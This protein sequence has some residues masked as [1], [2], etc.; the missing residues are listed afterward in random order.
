MKKKL[1]TTLLSLSAVFCLLGL[2]ACGNDTPTSSSSPEEEHLAYK[3]ADDGSSYTVM[4]MGT[5]TGTDVII[6]ATYQD[7]PVTAIHEYAF[8]NGKCTSITFDENSQ[9]TSIPDMAFHESEKLT[10]IAFPASLSSIGSSVFSGCV[11]LASITVDENNEYFQSIDDNLYSKD[12]KTLIQYAIGKTETE[13]TVPDSV[14]TINGIAFMDC[15]SL[16]SVT[17]GSEVTTVGNSAFNG[18]TSLT[19]VTMG[20]KVTTIGNSAFN[21]CTSLKSVTMGGKVT[22]VGDSA[23]KNC[24]SLTSM[25]LPEGVTSIGADAFERCTSLASINLPDTITTIGQTAFCDCSSLTSVSIPDGLTT[26][27][28]LTFARCHSLTSV[29]IP[30]NIKK[31]GHQAFYGC[32]KLKN[33]TFVNSIGWTADDLDAFGHSRD[34][35]N[36][37]ATNL[38]NTATAAK[39]LTDTYRNYTWTRKD[40]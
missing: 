16:T 13:F 37:S 30:E 3:L 11:S 35:A 31:I 21:G 27:S 20:G 14:T 28:P 36:I 7:L 10:S 25:I 2:A 1:L 15:T 40:K 22:T 29:S 9:I 26:I 33:V 17:L 4:G 18:C 39:Y 32:S 5:V 6:P 12:G 19:S 34:T 23:F 38:S 8:R 24:E